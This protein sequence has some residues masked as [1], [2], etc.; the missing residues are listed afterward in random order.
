MVDWGKFMRNLKAAAPG[1]HNLRPPCPSD[2]IRDAEEHLGPM[3]GDL[4]RMLE[5]F[6][7]AELFVAG[8]PFMTLL[9]LSLPS[10][11]PDLDWFI[12]RYTPAWRSF[13]ARPKDFVVGIP[14]YGA[15]IVLGPDLVVREWDKGEGQWSGKVLTYPEWVQDVLTEGAAF[16]TEE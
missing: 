10:D 1:V 4:K 12:D 11:P 3:P 5:V 9:G 6:N 15:V 7:G 2:R 16:L 14:C 13:A 8:M